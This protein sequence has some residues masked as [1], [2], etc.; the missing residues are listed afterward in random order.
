LF[1]PKGEICLRSLT[2]VRDDSRGFVVAID[3][4]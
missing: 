4:E 3:T 2:F 1:R